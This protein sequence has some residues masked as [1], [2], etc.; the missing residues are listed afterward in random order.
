MYYLLKE[1]IDVIKDAKPKPVY[2]D[3]KAVSHYRIDNWQAVMLAYDRIS[4]IPLF[5]ET[6]DSIF[7]LQIRMRHGKNFETLP[8]ELYDKYSTLHDKIVAM[9]TNIIEFCEEAGFGEA[10]YGFDIKMPPTK[11]FSEF[12]GYIKELEQVFGQCPYLK[13]EGEKIELH[14]TDSGSIWLEFFVIATGSFVLLERLAKIVDKCVKIKSHL[15]TCRQQVAMLKTTELKND[16]LENI[17]GTHKQMTKL[18]VD[19]FAEDLEKEIG[20]V[21]S[22]DKQRVNLTLE[23]LSNMMDKGLEIVASINAPTEI[24][25]LFPT[26]DEMALSSDEIKMLAD[27]DSSNGSVES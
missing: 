10:D 12:A 17:L 16:A 13:V 19:R 25:A 15:I 9:M 14:K 3:R 5:K 26:S 18:L 11:D 2:N 24:K 21:P 1:N 22:E 23:R 4:V 20:E 7:S 27:A 8:T 6:V